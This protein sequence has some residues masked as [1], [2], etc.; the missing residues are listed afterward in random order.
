[1]TLLS[2]AY[3]RTEDVLMVESYK[4]LTSFKEK[5]FCCNFVFIIAAAS[6]MQMQNLKNHHKKG[7]MHQG[8]AMLGLV[9]V[10]IAEET[11]LDMEIR[12][13]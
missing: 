13:F 5:N 1:M 9:T 8:F 10:A 6:F 11:G 7:G 3:A 12:A 4:L 2:C